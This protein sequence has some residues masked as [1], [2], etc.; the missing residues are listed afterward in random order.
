MRTVPH[1]KCVLTLALLALLVAPEIEA[2]PPCGRGKA[3]RLFCQLARGGKRARLRATEKLKRLGPKM[4][5]ALVDAVMRV[6]TGGVG[7]KPTREST[8]DALAQLVPAAGK[9]AVRDVLLLVK[10][11]DDSYLERVQTVLERAAPTIVDPLARALKH[12]EVK[13]RRAAARAL[14]SAKEAGKVAVPRLIAA[15]RD[16]DYL[17]RE[18]AAQTLGALAS[19]ATAAIAPL[20]KALA[21]KK[22]RVVV[23][24]IGALG[25]F[26]DK[27]ASAAPLY[28][29]LLNAKARP[30]LRYYKRQ[31]FQKSREALLAGGDDNIALLVKW[32]E[33]KEPL[34]RRLATVTLSHLGAKAKSAVPILSARLQKSKGGEDEVATMRALAAIGKAAVSAVPL[35]AARLNRDD[36]LLRVHAAST[37][38]LFGPRAKVAVPALIAALD[39]KFENARANRVKAEVA[40]ALA[41]IGPS[42]KAALPALT[43]ASK[44]DDW[45]VK[46][47]TKRALAAIRRK[48]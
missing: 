29:A 42:A 28:A 13:V 40:K 37:L 38:A 9:H 7:Q 11:D 21:D 24:A 22:A 15:L 6:K 3:G 14:V 23:A 20:K 41:A 33:A 39:D 12:R 26:G 25:K 43:R 31:L 10:R 34:T 47:A 32:L 17:V 19:V 45:Q 35:L 1:L 30:E 46:N 27:A 4:K 48:P 18:A 44:I 36:W 8:I 2:A 16:K 5:S